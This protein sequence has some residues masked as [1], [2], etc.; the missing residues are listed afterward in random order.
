MISLPPLEIWTSR[1]HRALADPDVLDITRSTSD[2][3]GVAIQDWNRFPEEMRAG[4]VEHHLRDASDRVRSGIILVQ[5][6]A[7]ALAD[8]SPSIGTPW[9]PSWSILAPAKG[10]AELA[11][12]LGVE[13]LAAPEVDRAQRISAVAALEAKSWAR[14]RD[15]ETRGTVIV[16]GYHGEMQR[17]WKLYP[18]SWRWLVSLKRVVLACVCRRPDWWPSDQPWDHCHRFL[19]AGLVVKAASRARGAVYRGELPPPPEEPSPQLGLPLG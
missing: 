12:R 2:K 8:G 4:L 18:M 3:H 15:G 5:A 16:P 6:Q 1:R 7:L 13:A 19:A 10:A 9:A 14:Y 17:S 11:D